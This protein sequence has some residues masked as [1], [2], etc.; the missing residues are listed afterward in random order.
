MLTFLWFQVALVGGGLIARDTLYRIR[1]LVYAHPASHLDYL[2]AKVLVAFGIPFCIQLPFIFLPW[3]LPLSLAGAG[4]PIWPTAPLHLVPAAALTSTVMASVALG[5]SSMS[6]TPKAGVGWALGLLLAPSAVGGILTGLLEN[7]AWMALSPMALTD[8]W[9]RLLCGVD[10]TMMPL[11]LAALATAA[12][13]ALWLYIA[14][15]R[16][17]P[18]EAVI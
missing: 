1:P 2:A 17:E 3:L 11:W 14:K 12:N 7:S 8:V 18:T 4:G 16:T 15:R 13:A 5:A 10:K 9:P 6:A